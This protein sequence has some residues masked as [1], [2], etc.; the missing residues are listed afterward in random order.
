MVETSLRM[1]VRHLHLH[2]HLYRTD[3]HRCRDTH[4]MASRTH[5]HQLALL[6]SLP[7]AVLLNSSLNSCIC[8]ALRPDDTN[9]SASV[10]SD[11]F[12]SINGWIR[13]L[14]VGS[15]AHLSYNSCKQDI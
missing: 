13:E 8:D 11:T 3:A 10:S 9:T 6:Q 2:L 5:H 12:A 7:D 1:K 15:L 4:P 14:K